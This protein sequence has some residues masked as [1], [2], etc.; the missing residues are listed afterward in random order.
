MSED[1]LSSYG[2][3][4]QIDQYLQLYRERSGKQPEQ[5]RILDFGCGTG[6]LRVTLIRRGYQAYGVDIDREALAIGRQFMRTNRCDADVFSEIDERNRTGF[7]DGFF[8]VIVSNQIVF[9][10]P[11]QALPA[12]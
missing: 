9:T 11:C 8:D 7:A 3:N 4:K 6:S 2:P 12:R 10:Y 5:I 1:V